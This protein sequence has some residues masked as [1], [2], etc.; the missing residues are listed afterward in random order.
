VSPPAER[1]LAPFRARAENL[2]SP[3]E[4]SARLARGRPLRLKFG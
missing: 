2:V 3:E 1:A 4:L